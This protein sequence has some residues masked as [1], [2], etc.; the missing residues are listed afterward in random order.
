MS[1]SVELDLKLH[2][3]QTV[4]YE[5]DATE[6]LYGGAAGG[7]KSHLMRVMAITYASQIPGLMVYL[8][9]RNSADLIKNHVEGRKGLRAMLAPW[10]EAGLVEIVQDE[11]RFLF[12]GSKIFL[13]HCNLERDR[14]KYQGAEIDL[15]LI[16][17]ITHFTEVIY[18]FLRSRLRSAN[19]SLPSDI[20]GT[21][22]KIISSGNPGGIGHSFVKEM[23]IDPRIPLATERMAKEEGGMLRQFIPAKLE[24]NPTMLEDDPTYE[25]R[26]SGLGSPEL[27]A[28]IRDGDWNV[29]VGSYFKDWGPQHIL[30]TFK[31]PLHWMRFRSL[32][33]GY[34]APFS[35]GWWA[36]SD[37]TQ[38]AEMKN[39]QIY[40]PKGALFRYREWY[41]KVGANKGVKME[42]DIVAQGVRAR[43]PANEKIVYTV[44]DPAV[45]HSQTGVSIAETFFKKDVPMR[46][47][48]NKRVPGWMQM[49]ERLRGEET[50]AGVFIP[51]VYCSEEFCRDSIRTIPALQYDEFKNEDLDTD[52]ED[53]AADDWRYGLMSR[54][55]VKSVKVD[56]KLRS[57]TDAS[58]S[59]LMAMTRKAK[60][61]GRG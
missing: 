47:G 45:F 4:A 29:V 51:M 42:P 59:E 24:D 8:F 15:L 7:G 13:C 22:P 37:G 23:W 17:E 20:P 34:S 32:D 46:P 25:D 21:L 2:D 57:E 28:A 16:D 11:I 9:R 1:L 27:V 60:R 19:L 54:P 43:T 38:S 49:R 52:G 39:K 10:V 55:W 40:V 48:D 41:G 58:F 5:S 14:W 61:R 53:H 26:L 31:V 3:K 50:T 33:W 18:R 35:I 12:N 6:I 30:P 44:A 56:K 36:V